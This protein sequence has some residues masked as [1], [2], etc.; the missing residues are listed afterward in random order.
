LGDELFAEYSGRLVAREQEIL[1]KEAETKRVAGEVARSDAIEDAKKLKTQMDRDREDRIAVLIKSARAFATEGRYEAGLGQLEALLALDPLDDEALTLKDTLDDMVYFK[2]ENDLQKEAARQRAKSLLG[3]VESGIPYE[4]EVTYPKNWAEIVEKPTRQPDAPLGLEP[5]DVRIYSQLDEVVDLSALT[6]TMPLSVA[7]DEIKN[8]VDPPLTMVVLWRDIYENAGV[9]QTTEIN[10]DG[11]SAVRLG[12]GL[13]NLLK[14]VAGGFGDDEIGYVVDNGVITIA[15]TL[16]LPSKLE[17]RVYDI[18]DLTGQTAN[19]QG[20]GG[21]YGGQSGGYGGQSGGY[22]GQGGRGGYGGGGASPPKKMI[23]LQTRDV[24]KKIEKLLM[25]LRKALG[26]QVSI[27]A[28]YLVVSENFLEDIG[29]DLDFAYVGGPPQGIWT[30]DQ[31][32]SLM[33][34]P[35]V[36]TKVPGSLGGVGDAMLIQG[37]YSGFILNDLQVSFLLRATQA[38]TDAKTLTAPKATVLSG[39]SASFTVQTQVSY[40]LPPDTTS[41][42]SPGG[43]GTSVTSSSV[44]QNISSIQVGSSLNISPII[45]HDKKNVLLYIIT[46]L[47][48]LLRMKTHSVEGPIGVDGTV[49]TYT[50]TVPETETSSV[51]TR[52]SV[53]DGGTLLLGGQKITAEIEKEAGVPILSKIP[54]LGRLFSNRSRVR[55]HKILLIL[56]K[57]TIILQEEREAEALAALGNRS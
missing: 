28:R 50:V 1:R 54:L 27:E 12:T 29:L 52:V 51:M 8:A 5:A 31:A 32:S 16:A 25:E 6:A 20:G 15:T 43:V 46:Q 47:Q 37:G 44:E 19:F 3:A 26:H 17:T 30:Y 33:T 36:S 24:H 14:A 57:P 48:D 21:G 7:L 53:P 10:M 4:N 42:V 35:D 23:V 22:G 11:L 39:E 56:V 13:D 45:T 49:Q 38:H 40:A 18:T 55:D 34:Q 2:R 41:N 9:E